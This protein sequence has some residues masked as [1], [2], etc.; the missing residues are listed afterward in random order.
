MYRISLKMGIKIDLYLHKI[1]VDDGSHSFKWI[2]AHNFN[3]F[4]FVLKK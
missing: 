1:K 3:S 4:F 2:N